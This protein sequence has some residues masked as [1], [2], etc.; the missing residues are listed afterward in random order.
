MNKTTYIITA[1]LG[2][3]ALAFVF[4]Q[5]GMGGY[6]YPQGSG[7]GM[8]GGYEGAGPWGAP[9]Y[10]MGMM[11]MGGYGMGSM[12]G[13]VYL[14][15]ARPLAESE[16]RARLE[17]YVGRFAPG[18]Q[19]RDL[20][21]FS[22]NYYAQM[23]DQDGRGLGEVLVDRYTGVVYPEPGPNMMWNRGPAGWSVPTRYDLKAAK[24]LA[25][26]FLRGY[27]PG[28]R[29]MEEQAFSGYYTFDFGRSEI[30]GMLSIN[31]YTGE[32]WVHTWHGPFLGKGR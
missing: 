17:S 16:A 6:G 31:A 3:A 24:Q 32:V 27:L 12:M 25:A 21:P 10:G 19:I 14:P 18:A 4:A 1:A 22:Q 2:L 26:D 23:V 13:G 9:G 11:G 30:E 20:M 15:D 7:Y 8:M 5:S 29:I 28:A